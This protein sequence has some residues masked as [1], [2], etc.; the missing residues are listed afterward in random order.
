MTQ[1]RHLTRSP[2]PVEL[3]GRAAASAVLPRPLW[4]GSALPSQVL[5]LW[6]VRPSDE[7]VDAY[8]EVT[9]FPVGP[10]LPDTFPS[11][12][13]FGLGLRLMTDRGFPLKA[14]GM[15]HV[16]DRIDVHRPIARG[17]VL[18]IS[19]SARNLRG[20]RKGTLVDL[21]TDVS[22]RGEVVWS[23]VSTYLS[24]GSR[25]APPPAESGGPEDSQGPPT[26]PVPPI[27]Q[28]HN[29]EV[30]EVPDDIGRRFAG[31]SG[32]RNPIH[33]HALSA[34]V[35]GFPRAIAHGRWTMAR[36]V[37]AV[38]GDYPYPAH[39]DSWFRA[40]V[41]LPSTCQLVMN[42]QGTTTQ[43]WLTSADR[44]TIHVYT[45]IARA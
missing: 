34:R 17:E 22:T 45:R 7:R 35:F 1:V 29:V 44:E 20:H 42:T 25:V 40:P 43:L 39:I 41:S 36:S 31:V 21:V 9:G 16:Q 4:G 23:E 8:C 24:R 30:V 37:A 14:L 13:G 19:V 12:L 33:L 10:T 6:D 26:S 5:Q 38:A 32:D 27:P 18:S 3:Y 2:W 15:V 28:I 11:L